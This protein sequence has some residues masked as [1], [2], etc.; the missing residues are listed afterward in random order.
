M[1]KLKKKLSFDFFDININ[2]LDEEWIQ[3]P[4]MYFKY[5]ELLTNAK[6]KVERCKARLSIA[7]DELKT[8]RAKLSLRIRKNPKKYF[9]DDSKPT[10]AAIDNRIHV[11]PMFAKSK[12]AIYKLTEDLISANKKVSTYYS[13]V[14]TLDHRKAALERLVSLFGQNY[15]SAPKADEFSEE[16]VEDFSNEYKKKRRQKA[17]KRK[18]NNNGQ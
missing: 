9:G 8:T 10:E 12:A 18:R 17:K 7:D 13:A 6:E 15:F 3:Q 4:K 5:S 1:K 16:A 14:H 2:R 11:H